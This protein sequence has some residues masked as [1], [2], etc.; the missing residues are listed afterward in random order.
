V[1][2]KDSGFAIISVSLDED[3]KALQR[4]VA[5]KGMTW[6]Q[7][8]DGKDGK[9]AELFNVTATPV[10]YLIGRDRKIGA[11]NIPGKKLADVIAEAMSK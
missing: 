2:F 4:M 7:I 11:K 1:K 9:L 6:P 8:Q 5:L 3:L 10:Y